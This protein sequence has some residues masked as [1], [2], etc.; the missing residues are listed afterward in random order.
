MTVRSV[1]IVVLLFALCVVGVTGVSAQGCATTPITMSQ[2]PINTD[3]GAAP[4]M[5]IYVNGTPY[6]A[7]GGPYTV[8]IPAGTITA[9]LVNVY[10]YV[11]VKSGAGGCPP[12]YQ[13][14]IGTYVVIKDL[15]TNTTIWSD[16]TGWS[17]W[18]YNCPSV[19]GYASCYFDWDD[20]R[21]DNALVLVQGH[22]YRVYAYA[23]AEVDWPNVNNIGYYSAWYSGY[24]TINAI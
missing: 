14:Q 15:T 9:G 22:Q 19:S 10:G 11:D 7:I 17:P 12:P 4:S 5:D 23:E 2:K 6:W 13:F 8:S 21:Y 3:D 18:V 24:V 20:N 1:A 16:N